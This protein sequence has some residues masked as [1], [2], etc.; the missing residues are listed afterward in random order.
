MG[1]YFDKKYGSMV[2]YVPGEQVKLDGETIKLNTNEN[3]YPPSEICLK[4]IDK[5]LARLRL[6]PDSFG[7]ELLTELSRF[8]KIG[9][10][11]IFVGN[12]SDEVLAFLFQGFCEKGAAFADLTYGFYKVFS[13]LYGV[14]KQIV[15]LRED[16]SLNVDDYI[17]IDKTIFLANPN[18]PTGMAIPLKDIKKLL[19]QDLNRLVVID[20]AYVDFGGESAVELLDDYDN[21]VI[22]M[23]FSKSRQLAGGRIGF[24]MASKDLIADMNKLKFSFNPFDVDG[25]T[26]YI[27]ACIL[28]DEKYFRDKIELVIFER[29]RLTIALKNLGFRVL[30]SK[31]NFVFA[32]NEKISGKDLCEKLK[33]K[34][35]YI[36]FFSGERTSPFVR[37][38]IG[39]HEQMS[40][41]ISEID[42][43]MRSL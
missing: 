3:P 33:D 28:R 10:D 37:I 26:Q 21:L 35:I 41:L 29:E 25:I 36:R 11:R 16:Y 43:I 39:T 19:E 23:T 40:R 27:G 31:S 17:G 18:A 38:T 14:E 4:E 22:V 34:K 32:S 7:G 15:P 9:S 8:Y 6:Y 42:N 30:N 1:K 13:N 2:P 24:A 5:A 20:E 12:G